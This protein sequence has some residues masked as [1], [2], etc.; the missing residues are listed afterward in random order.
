METDTHRIIPHRGIP[1]IQTRIFPPV[2]IAAHP[3]TELHRRMPLPT[4]LPGS[5]GG[6]NHPCHPRNPL[7]RSTSKIN[8]NGNNQNILSPRPGN[9][10]DVARAKQQ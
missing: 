2:G 3:L 10:G 5:R 7:K 6:T 4:A 8:R 9:A 1:A